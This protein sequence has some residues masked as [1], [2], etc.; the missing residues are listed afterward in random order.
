[1]KAVMKP[2][3]RLGAFLSGQPI[4]RVVCVPLILNH[5]ARVIVSFHDFQATPSN[6]ILLGRISAMIRQGADMGLA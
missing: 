5:A 2:R 1:M 3:Q 6:E 4:D